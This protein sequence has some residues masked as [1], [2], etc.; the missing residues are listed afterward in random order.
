MIRI[1]GA[2]YDSLVDDNGTG[3]GTI[4]NKAAIN[5]QLTA[6]DQAFAQLDSFGPIPAYAPTNYHSFTTLDATFFYFGNALTIGGYFAGTFPANA[7]AFKFTLPP[8]WFTPLRAGHHVAACMIAFPALSYGE[9]GSVQVRTVNTGEM[10]V[11]RMP[12]TSFVAGQQVIISFSGVTI[13]SVKVGLGDD[14]DAARAP[15]DGQLEKGGLE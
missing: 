14:P 5:G 8:G 6:I 7:P 9:I 3:N 12:Y 10:Q 11:L 13:Q 4:W 1:P 15:L 2:W